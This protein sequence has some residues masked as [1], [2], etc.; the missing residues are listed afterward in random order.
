MIVHH[1]YVHFHFKT[2][3]LGKRSAQMTPIY[4][5]FPFDAPDALGNNQSASPTKPEI[6]LVELMREKWELPLPELIISVTGGAKLFKL[7]PPRVR[8]AFQEGIVSAAVTTDAW[9]FTGG[10]YSGIMKEIGDAFEKSTCKVNKRHVRVPVI[11]IA[12]HEQLIQQSSQ[13]N[14][15]GSV[16]SFSFAYPFRPMINN[17]LLGGAN[18]SES[19]PL[20]P[21]HTHFILL[22]D[23]CGSDDDQWRTKN[24]LVRA[25]LGVQ[26]G[27]RIMQEARRIWNHGKCYKIPIVQLLVDGGPSSLLSVCE[28]VRHGTPKT[29]LPLS[30]Q[31]KATLND[32]Q[33]AYYEEYLNIDASTTTPHT[34]T[35]YGSIVGC[36]HED[37]DLNGK[38]VFNKNDVVRCNGYVIQIIIGFPQTYNMFESSYSIALYVIS[39]TMQSDSFQILNHRQINRENTKTNTNEFK[40]DLPDSTMYLESG[41]YLA[42][43]FREDSSVT[44]KCFVG[45]HSYHSFNLDAINKAYSDNKTI[46]FDKCNRLS[47]AIS[48][49]LVPTS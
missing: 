1:G 14:N 17:Y 40:F 36:C 39:P 10:S 7:T 45:S 46:V 37:I 23:M 30:R 2:Q 15:N 44:P 6:D 41:Q 26:L 28:A 38:V 49:Q 21:N 12:N 48:F 27:F 20:D 5:R 22:D 32:R 33:H 25:N 31:R 4:I 24:Y 42:V 13:I 16:R 3:S 8:K 34:G 43:G 9:V 11:A 18:E 19:Y 29:G 35:T 47:V